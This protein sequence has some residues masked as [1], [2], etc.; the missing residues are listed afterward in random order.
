[1]TEQRSE[2]WSVRTQNLYHAALLAGDQ[3]NDPRAILPTPTNLMGAFLGRKW[4]WEKQRE[5][6]QRKVKD[7]KEMTGITS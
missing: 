1:M 7:G 5:R 2:P 3:A 4:G 6:D